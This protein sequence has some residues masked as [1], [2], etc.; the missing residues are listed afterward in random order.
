M[1]TI[2]KKIVLE[3]K[4]NMTIQDGVDEFIRHCKIRNYSIKTVENYTVTARRF[5]R[6]LSLDNPISEL[7]IENVNSYI[8]SMQSESLSEYS[9]MTNIKNLRTIFYFFM[10]KGWLAEFKIKL[11]KAEKKL[12]ETYSDGEL[13]RLLKKPDL[14]KCVFSEYRNWVMVNFFI[15]TGIRLNSLVNIKILDLDFDNE[16]VKLTKTKSRKQ[17]FLP[18]TG[19]LLEVLKEYLRLRNGEDGDYLFCSQYGEKLTP[20]GMQSII[21]KYNHSRGVEKSSIHLF[22]HSFAQRYLLSGGDI[23]RLQKLMCH[24]DIRS[25]K[26]YLDL[27]TNDLKV[28]YEKFN[29][30]EQLVDKNR[31]YIRMNKN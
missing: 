25:T 27:C 23:F 16:V 4:D 11:P 19:T 12:K 22:R 1:E 7:Q 29:P 31:K 14:K 5:G 21:Q 8:L 24:N 10:M 28:N 15:G 9:V 3:A 17:V 2:R 6:F 13:K 26:E 18:I 30:L 20:D